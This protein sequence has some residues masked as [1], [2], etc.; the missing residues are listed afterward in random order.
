MVNMFLD[1]SFMDEKVPTCFGRI[2]LNGLAKYQYL[3][4][5]VSENLF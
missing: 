4:L 5:V 3:L 1:I 2:L